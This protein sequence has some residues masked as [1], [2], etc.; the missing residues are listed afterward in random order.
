MPL[1]EHFASE[2]SFH[3]EYAQGCGARG[4]ACLGKGKLAIAEALSGGRAHRSE[5]GEKMM[6]FRLQ[7]M[8]GILITAFVLSVLVVAQEP[9][10]TEKKPAANSQEQASGVSE[11]D[12]TEEPVEPVLSGPYPVMSQAAEDRG[13]QIFQ[14]FNHSEGSQIWAILIEPLKKRAGT[15]ARYVEFNKKLRERMGPE[16][17]MLEENIVPFIFAPDTIYSRLSY[18]QRFPTTPVMTSITIN[19]RGQIDSMMINPVPTVAE[20]RFAGYSTKNILHLPFNNEWLVYQGGRNAFDNGYA[21]SDDQRFAVDFVY[22][23]NGRMF[24]GPGGVG[25]KASDYYCFGQPILSPADGKVAKA[26]GGYDDNPP[27]RPS[28][29][30]A[31]G[32]V[33]SVVFGSGDAV[34]TAVFNHLKQNSL[35]VK[36]GDMVKQGQEL[37]E[38]GNSGAGPIPH[39]H[40]QLRKGPGTVI[41]AQFSDYIADG[42]PVASGE[43]K[44][45]QMV[46]NNPAAA[47]SGAGNTSA[48]STPATTPSSGK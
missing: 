8:V 45:G 33:V 16:T 21:M 19:Q 12:T 15:E 20:G 43:P 36:S 11:K 14:M 23:K 6:R 44:R 27:G 32:N 41:P 39:I 18:F 25:S 1:F 26:E 47:A 28:G 46:K 2:S 37:A 22:L 31:D 30:P 5:L 38:C 4:N 35:K 7:S 48:S 3:G 13:R 42:K 34:E 24:S 40:F 17:Q 9:A 10:A 29:D